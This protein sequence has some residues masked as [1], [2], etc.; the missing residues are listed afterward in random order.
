M[1]TSFTLKQLANPAIA[2]ADAVLRSCE[3]FGFCTAG[4]P[5]YVLLG[6]ENDAPRGR[7]DLIHEMLE[8]DA[9]P[10]PKTVAHL[11]RCLSCMSCMTTCAVRVDYRHLID[12]ARAHI[13]THHRRPWPDR[14]VRS[15]L[16]SV[17]PMPGRFR[18]A[19]ALAPLGKAALRVM[20]RQLAARV[21]PLVDMATGAPLPPEPHVTGTHGAA[22]RRVGRVLLLAGCA[23]RVLAPS[24][25]AATIRMLNRAGYDVTVPAA[26]G[27]CGSLELHMGREG[28]ARASA[29][30]NVRAW[31][32]EIDRGDVAAIVINASGCGSTVKDYGHLLSR[33]PMAAA[34]AKVAALARDICEFLAS[35]ELSPPESLRR[36]VVAVHDPCSLRNVQRVTEAP[37]T[38]LSRAGFVLRE[39]PE[40]HFCCG[41]A[42]TYNLLEPILAAQL[43]DRKARHI[44]GTGAQLVA[45]A[46]I[47][48]VVQLARHAD[49]PAIHPVEL[50]DW[51][52]GGPRPAALEGV[53]LAE[54][55]AAPVG[56]MATAK[57]ANPAPGE[58]GVSGFW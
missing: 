1:K 6:D 8:G 7:I 37:R 38:L 25:N 47:G 52:W 28:P 13:E 20:P 22:G 9:P 26:A 12:R 2:E 49:L 17:I 23:Q 14:L 44:A 5:T 30:A 27:C 31:T 16:A 29:R 55:F 18:A 32:A 51:A 11:D 42:G 41:S 4:C 35:V 33:D 45:A 56:A 19:L 10:E 57:P 43:G 36:Y 34:A 39:I 46:N 48:C 50:L 15:L 54:S 3:H 53:I 40:A 24:I 21:K 58:N